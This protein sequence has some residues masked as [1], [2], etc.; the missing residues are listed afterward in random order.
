MEVQ[1][2]REIGLIQPMHTALTARQDCSFRAPSVMGK[3]P[4]DGHNEDFTAAAYWKNEAG[5]QSCR[6]YDVRTGTRKQ[7]VIVGPAKA[8]C[9]RRGDHH[10]CQSKPRKRGRRH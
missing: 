10:C 4:Q 5:D 7:Y 9:T 8:L 6:A 3:V 2:Q 1:H